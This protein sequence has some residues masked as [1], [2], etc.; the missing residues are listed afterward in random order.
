MPHQR[1]AA[2][3]PGADAPRLAATEPS[4]ARFALK[5]PLT[6][7]Q[8][9]S[10]QRAQPVALQPR[11]ARAVPMP[12]Q[13]Q[14]QAPGQK[15]APVKKLPPQPQQPKPYPAQSRLDPVAQRL[16]RPQH[17]LQ[18]AHTAR[19]QA[20][21]HAGPAGL[22]LDSA[23]MR[24]R[25]VQRL[26]SEGIRDEA[27]L[28]AFM[29]VQRHS[30]VDSALVGQA[31]EDTSLPIGL[32]QTI[33]KPSVVAR[34][35]SL[36]MAG[37]TASAQGHLGR[38]LEIGT[39]CGYQAALLC[40]LGRS[41]VSIERLQALHDKARVNLEFVRNDSPR[42]VWGD[43]LQLVHGDGRAGHAPRAPYDTIIAAA[44][45]D[46]LPEAWLQQ[47]AP[48][49]RLVAPMQAPGSSQQVLVVVDYKATGLVTSRQEQVNFVP[50]KSG[51]A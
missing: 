47:L 48:G 15:Q 6:L 23:A 19:D 30:F 7:G 4:P 44:G 17:H 21:R 46:A 26:V 37:D 36:L 8:V 49:G 43:S 16:L 33:S 12:L 45:G 22:G 10:A 42:P 1:G 20:A 50:L 38:V 2:T 27:V 35:L 24:Q 41:V 13:A 28:N 18:Q 39:G 34:M 5:F 29:Q 11:P 40:L 31:Y 3:V 14:M 32:S 25:M 9:Q 51:V